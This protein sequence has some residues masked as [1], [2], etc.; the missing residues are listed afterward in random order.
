MTT[1]INNKKPGYDMA[2]TPNFEVTSDK[3]NAHTVYTYAMHS[4]HTLRNNNIWL[5]GVSPVPVLVRF[6]AQVCDRLISGIADSNPAEG[7]DV[8]PLRWLCFV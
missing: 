3:C 6:K 7:T 5:M 8:R 1:I 4:L 2:A